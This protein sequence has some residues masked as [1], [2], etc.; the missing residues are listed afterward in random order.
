MKTEAQLEAIRDHIRAGAFS[1]AKAL[2]RRALG[3]RLTR[4]ERLRLAYYCNEV[5]LP[6]LAINLLHRYI[7]P[8][9]TRS[10]AS[11]EETAEYGLALVRFGSHQEAIDLLASLDLSALPRAANVLALAYLR[12][13]NYEPVI[14]V[15]KKTLR[16]PRLPEF[17]RLLV[18]EH[19]ASALLHGRED[20]A[21]SER[22]L[23]QI[24]AET[25]ATHFRK[26]RIDAMYMLMQ[27]Q[28]LQSQWLP[29]LALL[30]QMDALMDESGDELIPL[31]HQKWRTVIA[32]QR[33][34]N[35]K[36]QLRKLDELKIHFGNLGNWREQRSCDYYTALA[37]KDRELAI[38][39]YFGTPFPGCRT[40]LLRGLGMTARDLPAHYDLTIPSR[41]TSREAPL[42]IEVR[43]GGSPH[44]R[45]Q[46]K[47]GQL[48]QRLLQI[49]VSDFYAPPDSVQLFAKLY[50][51]EYF[52]PASSTF[53][54]SQAI[55][56]LRAWLKANHLPLAIEVRQGV[57]WLAS[58]RHVVL[59]IT[60]DLLEPASRETLRI[61]NFQARVARQFGVRKFSAQE[62]QDFLE[63]S[64]SL[65]VAWLREG[66]Q[67][68][69]LVRWGAGP[70]TSYSVKT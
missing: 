36:A 61:A 6:H 51:D 55:K 15:M 44:S 50:P 30:D 39:V 64:R 62:L 67:N 65:A 68:R 28:L 47:A 37:L 1:K 23:R 22:L 34:E 33:R 7:R 20:F 56:R 12:Q 40:K 24:I 43:N 57:F 13:W 59:R 11:V 21:T 31:I 8:Q 18:K 19:L 60:R 53:R 63:V 38:R 16:H 45:R 3:A 4:V 49:L 70:S 52:N 27:N 54:V 46:L 2:I 66:C 17:D 41:A 69:T 9:R 35:V 48:L 5:L 42:L 10:D 32:L 58:D 14:A 29:A 25:S 26:A